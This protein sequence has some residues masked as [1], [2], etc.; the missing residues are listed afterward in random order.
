MEK[1]AQADHGADIES[2]KEGIPHR[3]LITVHG[4]LTRDVERWDYEGSGTTEDPYV[5]E[6]IENDPRNPMTWP[7]SKKWV[8][9]ISMAVATLTVSFCSSAFSGGIQQIIVEYH[10]SQEIVTLGISLFVLGFALGPRKYPHFPFR[11][12]C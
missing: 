10:T 6:W 3:K 4:A 1:D 7:N 12:T 5:V 2:G 11:E 8:M 9:C